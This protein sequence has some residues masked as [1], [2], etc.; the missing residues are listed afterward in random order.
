MKGLDSSFASAN[1]TK[2][3]SHLAKYWSNT[4]H[5]LQ[6]ITGQ[7]PIKHWLSGLTSHMKIGVHRMSQ[8]PVGGGKLICCFN[9]EYRWAFLRLIKILEPRESRVEENNGLRVFSLSCPR[10]AEWRKTTVFEFSA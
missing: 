2:G 5:E 6:A 8:S 10:K 3:L 9:T 7:T 1:Y 4:F